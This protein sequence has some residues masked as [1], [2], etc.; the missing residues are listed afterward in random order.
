Q[1]H[2]EETRIGRHEHQA[3]PERERVAFAI[4]RCLTLDR[5]S[6]PIISAHEEVLR[7]G[8]NEIADTLERAVQPSSTALAVKHSLTAR[9][10]EEDRE[11]SSGWARCRCLNHVLLERSRMYRHVDVPPC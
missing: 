7:C 8:G 9:G 6:P 4:H 2:Q 11:R 10:A 1:R 3:V 5:P